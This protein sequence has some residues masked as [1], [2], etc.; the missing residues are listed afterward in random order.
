[1]Q[2]ILL[3]IQTITGYAADMSE[4]IKKWALFL[5]LAVRYPT[6][7]LPFLSPL[8]QFLPVVSPFPVLDGHFRLYHR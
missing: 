4:R 1:M 8:S 3:A 7:T 5:L 6:L 2:D